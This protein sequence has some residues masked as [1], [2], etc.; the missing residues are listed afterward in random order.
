VNRE[1]IGVG[2]TTYNHEDY[3]KD[4]YNSIDLNLIDE[5]VVVNGGKKYEN[6][7]NCHWIQHNKNSYPSVCRNDCIT[8]LMNHGCD[9]IF[10]IEDDMIITDA[11]IFERYIKASKE[12]GLKYFSYVSTSD[13]SGEPFNRNPKITVEY[14]NNVKVNFFQNM[15]NEFT[16]HHRSCFEKVGLYDGNMREAFDVELAYRES[17]IAEWASPFWWFADIFDS[18]HFIKNNPKAISRLQSERPDGSRAEVIGKIWEYFNSKHGLF[19]P[20]IPNINKQEFLQ[21]IK[22]VKNS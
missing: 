13:G 4:L 5:L 20:E 6:D 10:L 12:S 14:K 8:F 21:K 17:L 19:V 11:L 16:Y 2:I 3:F 7:Y 1:K 18:D 15:C 22:A 9:H